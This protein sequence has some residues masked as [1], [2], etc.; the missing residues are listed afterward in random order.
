MQ[1]QKEAI[2][3]SFLCQLFSADFY[4]NK[5]TKENSDKFDKDTKLLIK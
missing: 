1:S 2:V 5:K 4:S 3:F